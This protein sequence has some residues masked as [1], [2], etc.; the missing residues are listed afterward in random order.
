VSRFILIFISMVVFMCAWT[1]N[2]TKNKGAKYDGSSW[3]MSMFFFALWT[4]F[5]ETVQKYRTVAS[6][7]ILPINYTYFTK[8]P[9]GGETKEIIRGYI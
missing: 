2:K 5:K 6:Y 1:K 7:Q 9:K 3:K 8:M 4:N